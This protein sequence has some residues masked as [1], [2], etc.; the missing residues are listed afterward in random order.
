[1]KKMALLLVLAVT[2]SG[3]SQSDGDKLVTVPQRYVSAEGMEHKSDPSVS[4]WVGIG[5]EIGIATK[6]GLNSVVDVSDKF[7][8]TNVGMFVMLMVA[9]R[10]VGHDLLRVV[11][12]L[13]IMIFGVVLWAWSYRRF[14]L[15]R[16]VLKEVLPDKKKIYEHEPAY[17]FST[18]D[19][20]AGSAWAHALFL[21][22]W[23][24]A[25]ILLIF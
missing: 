6:E 20:R 16:R 10:I 22:A 25:W 19:A 21:A 5:K 7:S 2:I 15:G 1:M 14:F 24:L 4:K 12:G 23:L 9:W 17:E 3:Q 11:L 18:S 13:P 8:K